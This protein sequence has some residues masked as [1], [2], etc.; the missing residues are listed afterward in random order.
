MSS[1]A[2]DYR[3]SPQNPC[4]D[5]DKK[6]ARMQ[7][8]HF[9]P[10]PF[11]PSEEISCITLLPRRPFEP[12]PLTPP[13]AVSPCAPEEKASHEFACLVVSRAFVGMF[14]CA[15]SWLKFKN[16]RHYKCYLS[17]CLPAWTTP[18]HAFPSVENACITLLPRRPFEPSPIGSLTLHFFCSRF[19]PSEEKSC[20]HAFLPRKSHASLYSLEGLLNPPPSAVSPCTSS[21]AV[22]F[23]PQ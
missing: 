20:R 18:C 9:L 3:L 22:F 17:C 11:F 1:E 15:F 16:S 13:S 12:S 10:Q 6:S 21:A 23:L 8:Q 14:I 5:R 19:F 4:R 7:L 2:N